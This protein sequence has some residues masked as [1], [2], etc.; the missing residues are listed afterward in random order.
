MS[1]KYL[2]SPRPPAHPPTQIHTPIRCSWRTISRLMVYQAKLNEKY[3]SVLRC[4]SN[5]QGTSYKNLQDTATSS[6]FVVVLHQQI[7]FLQ[8]FRTSFNIMK[9]IFATNF[10]CLMDSSVGDLFNG[11]NSLSI[12]NFFL[13]MLPYSQNIECLRCPYSNQKYDCNF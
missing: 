12:T 5:F 3:T 10:S 2:I 13:L 8:L 11:R 6:F 1:V 9:K 7:S 4:I